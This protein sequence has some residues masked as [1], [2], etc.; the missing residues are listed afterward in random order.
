[1]ITLTEVGTILLP[2]GIIML[3]FFIGFK[4]VSWAKKQ[5][6]AAYVFGAMVQML[7]PD[8]YVERTIQLVQDNK[9]TA[10]KQKER[11]REPK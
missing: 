3:I 7:V 8:P 2:W 6:S 10:Q 4:L 9:K 1:M 11:E 5:N